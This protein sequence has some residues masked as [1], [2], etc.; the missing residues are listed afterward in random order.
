MCFKKRVGIW[1]LLQA[2]SGY[3]AAAMAVLTRY[4]GW[5]K[6]EVSI[7]VSKTRTDSRDRNIHGYL[8]LYV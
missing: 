8:D 2:E 7:L 1:N 4:E 3:E 6:E 5:L